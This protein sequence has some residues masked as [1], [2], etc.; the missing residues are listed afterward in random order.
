V[1]TVQAFASATELDGA[2]A[3]SD[4]DELVESDQLLLPARNSDDLSVGVSTIGR[5]AK[6]GFA[7]LPIASHS[8]KLP[9]RALPVA[10]PSSQF[11]AKSQRFRFGLTRS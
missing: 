2:G 9:A 6:H 3:K 7:F 10:H 11:G 5:F 4:Q 1:E 8:P